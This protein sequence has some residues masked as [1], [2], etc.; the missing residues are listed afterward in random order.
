MSEKTELLYGLN[1]TPSF[2]KSTTAA[3]Q[4]VLASFVGVVTPTLIIAGAL[5]LTA[6]IPFLVSMALF[7]SGLG[8]F[9]QTKK[10]GPV[11]SGLVAIQ[12]TSFAFVSALILAGT[13]VRSKGGT[14]ADVMAMLLGLSMAGAVVEIILSLFIDKIK[15]LLNPVTTGIVI[16]AIGLSLIEVGMTDLAGGFGASDFGSLDH[17]G[18]GLSVLLVIILLNASSNYWLRLSAI[19]IGMALGT[20]YVGLTSGITFSH[21]ANLPVFSL[22]SPL[23]F[24]LDFDLAL[25]I[26][27]ALIYCFSAI[28]TAG[29][30]TANSLFCKEPITGPVYLKRIKGG[31]LGD[32]VNS[33]I[34]ALFNT[35][36]NTTFGQN[37]GVIQLT[38]I[39]S[40]RVGIFIGIFYIFL[41]VFPL[42]G[43]L[44]Q[45]VPKAVLGGATLVMF[46]MVAVGGLKILTHQ[47]LD[48]RT[49]LIAASS[50]G[51]SMGVMMVP[52]IL[53]QMP[54]WLANIFA[55][56][57]TMAGVTA[58][59]LDI[60]L[61]TPPTEAPT[62]ATAL[63][64]SNTNS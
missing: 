62:P 28:E 34:A 6:Q 60:I 41:G 3:F 63:P 45:A 51:M 30:L 15:H 46:A 38:G 10:I 16:T 61:P 40:R 56:P 27:V 43:G 8:T 49:S 33:V 19:F 36:P 22:P 20:A 17:V 32:G 50:F 18:L 35:F 5:D 64:A 48:R 2:L 7:V 55:S 39:A 11:G 59:L 25:F 13:S 58:V 1:D 24:G 53:S 44:L 12:G 54:P 23:A 21:L 47:P 52:D 31:I 37:N 4:H 29:D 26:P 42:V 57:V 9:I 14:D